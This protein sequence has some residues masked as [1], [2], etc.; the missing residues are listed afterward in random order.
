MSDLQVKDFVNYAATEANL[1]FTTTDVQKTGNIKSLLKQI[2]PDLYFWTEGHYTGKP[3]IVFLGGFVEYYPYNEGI[4]TFLEKDFSVFFVESYY[5][6]FLQKD[7]ISLDALFQAYEDIFLVALR[8]KPIFMITGYCSGAEIA[9]AF[10]QYMLRKHPDMS[11]YRV[12][13]ME[14]IYNR[15]LY[16]ELTQTINHQSLKK[17]ID[18]F[19]ELY[20]FLPNL[21]YQGPIINVM[22][23]EPANLIAPED[24]EITDPILLEKYWRAWQNN[25]DAWNI[26]YTNDFTCGIWLGNLDNSPITYAGGNQPT[27]IVKN[28]FKIIGDKSNFNIPSSIVEKNIDRTELDENHRVVLANNYIPER[29]VQKEI[30][31]TF[32]LPKD[33]SNK[34]SS[35]E[36]PILN[37]KVEG[38]K[39]IIAFEAKDYLT[40]TA[41][42]N[43]KTIEKISGKNL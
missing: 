15:T 21:D 36:K 20:R 43:D 17:R 22:A 9:I 14:A 35:I 19:S 29:Y 16:N 5:K 41:I 37:S 6:F 11:P 23:G 30:F 40:Y 8:D 3:V 31:S 42:S 27:E 7:K 39:A 34:F 24:G 33:V 2:D 1:F 10:A 18:I 13:N 12:L 28:Y 25:L 32:N 38:N 4:A 26:S